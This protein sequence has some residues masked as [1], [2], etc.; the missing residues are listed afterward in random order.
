MVVACAGDFGVGCGNDGDGLGDEGLLKLKIGVGVGEGGLL[1]GDGGFGFG[2]GS[3]VIAVVE[4]DEEIAGAHGLVVGQ[5][6]LRDEA[7]NFGSDRCDV[8]TDIG[9]VGGF[10]E[11]AGGK[12]VMGEFCGESEA[13]DGDGDPREGFARAGWYGWFCGGRF[14][15]GGMVWRGNKAR[16]GR[17]NT[18]RLVCFASQCFGGQC[19]SG[20]KSIGLGADGMAGSFGN[21]RWNFRALFVEE[22]FEIVAKFRNVIAQDCS[23]LIGLREEERSLDHRDVKTREVFGM[24]RRFW[25]VGRFG[26]SEIFFEIRGD[27]GE[28]LFAGLAQF[29]VGGGKFLREHADEATLG[30]FVR[31]ADRVLH[32]IE[33]AENAIER[34]CV[35]AEGGVFVFVDFSLVEA[36]DGGFGEVIFAFEVVKESA[37]GHAGSGADIIETCSVETA[38]S[39]QGD[40]GVDETLFGVVPGIDVVVVLHTD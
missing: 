26:F 20:H 28:G 21:A 17:C 25:S 22:S 35:F 24:E 9:V 36:G 15:G 30:H 32:E 5:G 38:G 13:E 16:G 40:T 10:D 29:G 39:D 2:E 14:D 6:D 34:V 18:D 3:D 1:D 23:I 12:P 19:F 37:F 7:G 27:G 33:A 11:A 4:F 31:S 8:A